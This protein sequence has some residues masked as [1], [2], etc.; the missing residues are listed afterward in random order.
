MLTL[1]LY[2]EATLYHLVKFVELFNLRYNNTF[3]INK[4]FTV[5]MDY[6][7]IFFNTQNKGN[8][9]SINK[10]RMIKSQK[11]SIIENMNIL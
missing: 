8:F 4:Y 7:E 6:M 5:K 3:F 2:L 1:I 9:H 11:R 10:I